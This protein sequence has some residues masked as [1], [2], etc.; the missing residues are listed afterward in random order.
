MKSKKLI[1]LTIC[2]VMALSLFSCAGKE[3]D[4]PSKTDEP[5]KTEAPS[6]TTGSEAPYTLS[7]PGQLPVVIGERPT[8]TLLVIPNPNIAD[9]KDNEYTRW[10]EESCNVNL[11][12]ELLPATDATDKLAIMISSG[13]TLPDIVNV[14]LN[15]NVTAQYGEAGAF[16]SLKEYYDAGLAVNVDKAVA[17]FPEMNLLSNI[18]APNGEIYGFPYIQVSPS[19]ETKYKMWINETY[20]QN[21]GLDMPTTTEEFYQTLL[22][23][24]EEDANGDGDPNN[25]VPLIGSNGWG[26]N[27]VKFLT[28]AFVYEGD[29]DMFMLNNGE[30]TTSYV[31]DAWFDAVDYL[32]KLCDEGLLDPS[33]FTN[34][35]NQV[36]TIAGTEENLVGAITNSSL[37]YF[38]NDLIEYRLRYQCVEPLTGPNGVK[39]VAY[40]ASE[41]APRWYITPSCE[42]P[43]I[44][45]RV[46]DF[47]YT[48]E[49]F[50]RARYGEEGLHWHYAD[51]YA[52]EHDV[53]FF[54]SYAALGYEAKYYIDPETQIWDQGPQNYNWRTIG[55][56]FSGMGECLIGYTTFDKNGNEV[57]P[58]TNPVLRQEGGSCIYQMYKPGPDLY[59]P[60]LSFTQ[61][62]ADII[63]EI[64]ANLR[65]YVNEQRTL[66]VT[67]Q[68][69]DI[70]NRDDFMKEL[71]TIGLKT[72]LE[73][74]NA[75]YTRQYK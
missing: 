13:D 74:A 55:P 42:I 21:L 14:E 49:G 57:S 19:N 41:S 66:Y 64:Q 54:A 31:Q 28:N 15:K 16:I 73:H 12:F 30:V 52:E 69:S 10:V 22:A 62:E 20:L 51:K 48:E 58:K 72:L 36:L 34:D 44:A 27:I 70:A 43:E 3:V 38:G 24:K 26:S 56:M 39:T 18:T 25:E 45:F 32:K 67:G 71:E 33:S 5:S 59:V 53:E 8:L 1:A 35:N 17:E 50:M 40:A 65:T 9:F 37:A 4:S 23:F 2:I 11:E 47:Q 63:S 68:A 46:G 6:S 29:N 61:E 7:E 60:S 75:A